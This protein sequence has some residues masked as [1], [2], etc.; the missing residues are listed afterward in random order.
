MDVGYIYPYI[1]R[2]TQ[3]MNRVQPWQDLILEPPTVLGVDEFNE[4]HLT[5][6]LWIKTK[7]LKQWDVARE[8]R[9]RLKNAFDREGIS[10][11]LPHRTIQIESASELSNL[12]GR[13]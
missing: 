12:N 7:P 8:Y 11:P 10:N 6:R 4:N 13:K 9:R 1:W 2:T 5:I 3:E